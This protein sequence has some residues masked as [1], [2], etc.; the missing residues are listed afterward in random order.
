MPYSRTSGR[1]S[2]GLPVL[3]ERV[4]D[5]S[6]LLDAFRQDRQVKR[7]LLTL[8]GQVPP[9]QRGQDRLCAFR[10]M[11]DCPAWLTVSQTTPAS[12][13]SRKQRT[14]SESTSESYWKG[15][16][17]VLSGFSNAPKYRLV[18]RFSN[19]EI[20]VQIVYARLQGDF[21]LT[22]ARSKELPRYGI[23]HGLTNWTAGVY[24]LCIN[25][26]S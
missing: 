17:R 13:W 14:N 6:L 5:S 3:L 16:G 23:N 2:G 1:R 11:A 26:L 10:S 9:S 22:A 20:T 24:P 25:V 18:V 4:S 8:P 12:V 15:K 21:V 7:V 19:K